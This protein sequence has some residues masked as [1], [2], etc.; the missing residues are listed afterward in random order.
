MQLLGA[1]KAWPMKSS[2]SIDFSPSY[3]FHIRPRTDIESGHKISF[4]P[5]G[6][7]VNTPGE[8]SLQT[9][10]KLN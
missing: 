6:R 2:A 10:R 4:I 7:N 5:K 8:A 9:D 3:D 1:E